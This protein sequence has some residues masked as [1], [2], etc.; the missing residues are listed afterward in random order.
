MDLHKTNTKWLVH[1]CST[2]SARTSHVRPRTHKT[3]HSLDSREAT[4][5]PHIV[6]F[7]LLHKAHI[8]MAFCPGTPKVRTP[9]TLQGYNFVCKP[10]IEMTSEEKL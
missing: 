9:A 7:V 4:T 6:Y 8:Q 2:L 3:H 1:S 5:F 10:L